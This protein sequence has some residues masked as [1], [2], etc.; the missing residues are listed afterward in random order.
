M[1]GIITL[2]NEINYNYGGVL[3]NYALCK[4][5][6]DRKYNAKAIHCNASNSKEAIKLFLY[7]KCGINVYKNKS[8]GNTIIV[9]RLILER[10]KNFET[11]INKYIPVH[12]IAWYDTKKFEKLSLQYSKFIV[13]SD[14]VWNP[15]WAITKRTYNKL[16][17]RFAPYEKRVSYAASFGVSE[18][19]EECK[20]KYKKALMDFQRISVREESG[21]QIVNELI[22]K[23]VDVLIDPTMLLKTNEWRDISKKSSIHI[24][25]KYIL[26]YFLGNKVTDRDLY[27]DKI[28]KKYNL[29]II[30]LMD[31][32]Q[33]KIFTAGPAEFLYLIENASLIC[34]DSFHA[35][36]FS[37]LFNKPFWIMN[38]IEK[39]QRSMNSRIETL[40]EKLGL[41]QRISDEINEKKLFECDYQEAYERLDSE[42]KKAFNFIKSV[43]S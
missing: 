17:L 8:L 7:N 22:G 1:I 38:R 12:K 11:F 24:K 28:S 16:F 42:R 10:N 32:N 15:Y 14:Q 41:K 29:E 19:P 6:C 9:N 2:S 40:L 20:D 25:E 31:K 13:G 36:V 34:T 37:I 5:L 43:L 33:K 3:Q 27:I 23:S 35:T 26:K 21:K 4:Y 18:L 30:D 39:N